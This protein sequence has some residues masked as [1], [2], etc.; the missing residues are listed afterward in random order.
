MTRERGRRLVSLAALA[1]GALLFAGTL[2]YIDFDMVVATGRRLGVAVPLAL[3]A[4]GAWHLTRTWAWW[5]CFPDRANVRFLRL[6][7]VRLAAEAFSYLTIS[8]VAGE[9]L[10]VVLL[11]DRV[12][13]REATAAVA[14]ERI[15]YIVGT[16]IIVGLGA[17]LTMATQPLTPLWF[18]IFRAFAIGAGVI[19]AAVA[20]I[21]IRRDSY[22]L[23]AFRAADRA[24]GTHVASG[25]VGRFAADV[26][27]QLRDLVR[28]NPLRLVMLTVA[29]AIA[30]ACMSAEAYLI[31]RAVGVPI[32]FAGALAIETFSRVASFASGVIPASIGALEASSLA[33]AASVGAGVA[34]APLALA[35]RLRGLFWA[36]VGLAIYPRDS[37]TQAATR[38]TE[39]GVTDGGARTQGEGH[40]VEGGPVLLYLARQGRLF[41]RVAGLSIAERV[42]RSAFRA[43]YSRAVVLVEET[44]ADRFRELA[45]V[46]GGVTTIVENAGAWRDAVAGLGPAAPVTVIGPGTVVSPA[47]LRDAAAMKPIGPGQP[48]D[49]PAGPEWPVSGVLR[50]LA[51]DAAD[52][53]ALQRELAD[54][55]EPRL[56]LPSGED[57]S[58]QRGRLVLHVRGLADLARAEQTIRRSSYKDTDNKLARWNRTVSLP[59]SVVLIRT[60]LTANQLS[61]ALVAIGFYSAWLFSLGHY[62]AGVLGGFLSL[63]ASVLDGCDGEIARLKYQ[64]SALGCWIETF[65][66]YSYY[67]AIFVGLTIGAVRMTGWPVFYWFGTIALTGTLISFALLI[68]LRS[69]IT[70]GQ[71]DKLHTIAKARFKAEPSWWSRIIWRISF[72]ATR[73]AMPYGIFA[74]SLAGLLPLVVFLA[75]V[76]SNTYWISLVL[77]LRHLLGATQTESV[78]A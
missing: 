43:G 59:I 10:K 31:L 37:K 53:A 50:L 52:A 22:L 3:L 28:A 18:K 1:V 74:L 27:Q 20:L 62:W 76:G 64:E 66:D 46:I 58:H 21:L 33:A 47:L 6:A 12:P 75:A 9:P 4:S 73:S 69:R 77:K 42:L 51:P 45:G 61:V 35:R 71:P 48:R 30:Y 44:S 54:R 15:A 5:W 25:R 56:P 19:V 16:V 49:V 34:G 11:G 32:S 39:D 72:V 68:Y 41:D 57:V 2:Y 23:A 55:L 14:L 26:G 7:R 70:A 63:A 60:P 8:G 40:K 24:A 17:V 13:G 65:G 29:S 67:L 38:Q 36:G 78:A